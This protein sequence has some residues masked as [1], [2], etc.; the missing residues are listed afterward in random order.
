ME[1]PQAGAGQE[2]VDADTTAAFSQWAM[3]TLNGGNSTGL[4]VVRGI[5]DPQH[6]PQPPADAPLLL[7]EGSA[8]GEEPK[9]KYILSL[10]IPASIA[11][12]QWVDATLLCQSVELQRSKSLQMA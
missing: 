10:H 8:P 5:R 2:A 6:P 9:L 12:A 3:G 7:L 4:A 11:R 1:L